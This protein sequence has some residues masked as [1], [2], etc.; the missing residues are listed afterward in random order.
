MNLPDSGA[1]V[2]LFTEPIIGGN[3]TPADITAA[4][5]DALQS[6]QTQVTAAVGVQPNWLKF[7]N[8]ATGG[9][10]VPASSTGLTVPLYVG[11]GDISTFGPQGA[12]LSATTPNTI[13]FSTPGIYMVDI[14]LEA[15]TGTFGN[16]LTA[17]LVAGGFWPFPG[18]SP[19]SPINIVV[20]DNSKGTASVIS[21]AFVCVA[22]GATIGLQVTNLDTVNSTQ[23]HFVGDVYRI[24]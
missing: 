2:Q 7:S 8:D 17:S 10:T 1:L 15:A 4:L 9:F 20:P 16:G 3:A 19:A 14:G 21:L 6:L 11:S 24:A 22:A 18:G 13:V 12:S 5:N 23:L